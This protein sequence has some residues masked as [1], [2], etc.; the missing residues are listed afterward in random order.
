MPERVTFTLLSDGEAVSA[1]LQIISVLVTREANRI[2]F[3]KVIIADGDPAASDFPWSNAEDFAPGKQLTVKAGKGGDEV[4]IFD[5][6]VVQHQIKAPEG[7]QPRLVLEA[8]DVVFRSTLDRRN[9]ILEEVTDSDALTEILGD[10]DLEADVESTDVTHEALVQHDS[11]DW[12]FIMDRAYANGKLIIVE[13]GAIKIAAPEVGGSPVQ[14][15]TFGADV[16]ELEMKMDARSQFSA[17]TKKGWLQENQELAEAEAAEPEA[18]EQGNLGGSDLAGEIEAADRFDHSPAEIPEQMLQVWA[19]AEMM[20]SRLSRICGRIR[21]TGNADVKP[22]VTVELVGFGERFSGVAY[23]TGVRHE[24]FNGEWVMDVQVGLRMDIFED[25]RP[26]A[27][28]TRLLPAVGGLHVGKVLQLQEDPQGAERI[29]VHV[30]T[31]HDEGAGVWSRLTTLTAGADRGMVFRPEI[32][33]E[34]IVG[35]LGGDPRAAIVVGAVHSAA[36]ASPIEASDD[37][38]EK[39]YVSRSG[40]RF[41]FNDETS[42][43][44]L[45]TPGGHVLILDDD[46]GEVSLVDS[47]GNSMVMNADGIEIASA[48]DLIMTAAGNA[49]VTADGD[50]EITAS[51]DLTASGTNVT[52]DGSSQFTGSGGSGAE[53]SSGGQT[54]V[55]GSLV[56]IN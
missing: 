20:R 6:I 12:D 44:T 25:R 15:M 46:A 30:P 3:A 43:V 8:R 24:L 10:Y 19:D 27:S 54:V 22:G 13:D 5:G 2:P 47:N 51:G 9:R 7:G 14:T 39:G 36:N 41:I 26:G 38:H 17:V 53:L 4:Q 56:A 34:V 32:E 35:F 31:I 48:A 55:S 23:V 11:S 49:T 33:D 52:A 42:T 37:N 40:I 45:E 29:L 28:F 18:I 21:L 50:V 1:E 16:L